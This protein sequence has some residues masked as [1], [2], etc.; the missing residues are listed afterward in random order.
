MNGDQE[1][2]PDEPELK[3]VEED[4]VVRLPLE[5]GVE[6]LHREK[7]F[8]TGIQP[9]LKPRDEEQSEDLP[10][11]VE[12]VD[13]EEEWA[14]R[15][16]RLRGSLP[17]GF[18][19]LFGVLLVGGGLWAI[20]RLTTGERRIE[21]EAEV[22]ADRLL[23]EER[24]TQSATALLEMVEEQLGKYLAAATVAEKVAFVRHPE[25]V[26]PLMESYYRAQPLVPHGYERIGHFAPL[27]LDQIPFIGLSVELDDGRD[28]TLLIEQIGEQEVRFDWESEVAY[29]PMP[30]ADYLEQRPEEPMD[31]RVFASFDEFHAFEFADVERWR[32][33]YLT[34]RDSDEYLFAY[35][36]R[37]S[38]ADRKIMEFIGADQKRPVPLLLRLR[39]LPGARSTRSVQ[40]DEVLAPRWAYLE[41]PAP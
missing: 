32:S 30:L 24:R 1:L 4:H 39:F 10:E 27:A 29:Q 37:E 15:R 38:D 28:M 20:V 11:S 31:F 6:R 13:V 14:D 9:P 36:E 21:S 41:N 34:A 7:P 23:E 16:R 18:V 26:E 5:E 40:V 25:R 35:V 22:M 33:L 12:P 19:I 8:M 3:I 2:G 17:I